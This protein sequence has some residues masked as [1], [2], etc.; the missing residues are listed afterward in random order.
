MKNANRFLQWH[1]YYG[2]AETETC[3]GAHLPRVQLCL[4]APEELELPGP[5]AP[6]VAQVLLRDVIRQLVTG[7]G[8]NRGISRAKV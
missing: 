7:A 4:A 8:G 2:W 5:E 3:A 1:I 6:N